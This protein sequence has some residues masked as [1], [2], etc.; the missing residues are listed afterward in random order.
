[1]IESA[2]GY[3]ALFLVIVEV[4]VRNQGKPKF[5]NRQKNGHKWL[6][7]T[8]FHNIMVFIIFMVLLKHL[9]LFFFFL[10]SSETRPPSSFLVNNIKV[11]PYINL[12][13]WNLQYPWGIQP[14][15]NFQNGH[16]GLYP[17]PSIPQRFSCFSSILFQFW[18]FLGFSRTCPPSSFLVNNSTEGCPFV[19]LKFWNLKCL[20]GCWASQNFKM[21]NTIMALNLPHSMT[22]HSKVPW[23]EDSAQNYFIFRNAEL[24]KFYSS[25]KEQNKIR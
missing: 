12:K 10:S 17:I 20:W 24:L 13:L 8:T 15:Q 6:V 18:F 23:M 9:C 19:N 14:S 1:M 16:N 21:H 5:P 4:P 11:A 2:A 22:Y 25:Q 3:R 7:P